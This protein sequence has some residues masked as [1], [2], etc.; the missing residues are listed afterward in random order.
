MTETLAWISTALFAACAAPQAIQCKR[1]GHT[2]G[3]NR[4]FIWL[5]FWGEIFAFWSMS[6]KFGWDSVAYLVNYIINLAFLLVIL[7]YMYYPRAQD[8][9]EKNVIRIKKRSG[10]NNRDL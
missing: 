2:L 4:W 5:W 6:E 10:D 3:I 9:E 8:G 7:R 1:Q